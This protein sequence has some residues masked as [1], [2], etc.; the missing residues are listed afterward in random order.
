MLEAKI[1]DEQVLKCLERGTVYK[2]P[3]WHVNGRE[4]RIRMRDVVAGDKIQVCVA[5]EETL[6][7]PMLVI[8]TM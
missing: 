8:T 7:P 3:T 2:D 6:Q 5:F 4:W 1:T